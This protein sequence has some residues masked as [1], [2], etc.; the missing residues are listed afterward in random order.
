MIIGI[1]LGTTNS[2]ASVWRDGE[3]VLVPNETG[4]FLLPSVVG[5]DRNNEIVVGEAARALAEIMPDRVAASFKRA[6]G[7]DRSFSLG[8]QSFRADEL[9]SF[10]LR[11][12]KRDAERFLGEPVTDAVI[13]VPAYF[14][15][16]QRKATRIAGQLAGLR[17]ERVLNEPTA[18]ALAYGL[19]EHR[20][21]RDGRVLVFDLGGGT[22]DVSVIDMLDGVMEVRATAGDNYLGGDDFDQAVAEWFAAEC[23]LPTPDR[24]HPDANARALS[25]SLLHAA[26][27]ARRTLSREPDAM[28][29]I[30]H[31]GR[32]HEATLD[33]DR[34]ATL[35]KP[36]LERLRRPVA[37]ALDDSRIQPDQLSAVVLAGG[38]TRMPAV[39]RLVA[40]MLGRLPLQ[41]HDPDQVV[42]LGA[43]VQAG[44]RMRDAALDD[45]VL[46][47]VAPYTL[48]VEVSEQVGL[49]GIASGRLL[50]VIERGSA[51][52]VSRAQ[53]VSPVRDYQTAVNVRVFQ[54]ESRLAKDNIPLGNLT[55]RIEPRR[56]SEQQ[57]EIRF[58][59]DANGLLEVA[60]RSLPDG[61]MR[62]LV[63]EQHAG[64]LTPEQVA[65]RLEALAP[66]KLAP[67]D[68]VENR[69]L[70]ARA[71]RLHERAT[72]EARQALVHAAA[73]FEAALK[74]D[75]PDAI[76]ETRQ[77][78]SAFVD[79]I[80]QDRSA[81]A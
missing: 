66:L 2:L 52:P 19:H 81:G 51:V 76:D 79:A 39:R 20:A 47:D 1:D 62:S 68:M 77:R 74:A 3:A 6:M 13:T 53:L 23:S 45:V 41:S 65:E 38:A 49:S 29:R 46:T 10:V 26:E 12:L 50:P 9:S 70:L 16:A 61:E 44:L 15:D 17:V 33:A 8:A 72:G 14:S 59:Y 55:L 27:T 57:V 18:A 37:R 40:A 56:I 22:F 58:T 64:V 43:A 67:R 28:M 34:F 4:G 11:A 7:T 73:A 42:A 48:G 80:E 71:D 63:I 75:Q 35:C 32:T 5:L 21:G 60:A 69:L 25:M 78:L 54:G 36:L 24:L 31:D 30:E